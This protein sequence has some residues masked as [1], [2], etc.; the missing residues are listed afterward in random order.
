MSRL[1]LVILLILLLVRIVTVEKMTKMSEG[2]YRY[3]GTRI[4][5]GGGHLAGACV[6]SKYHNHPARY[7]R[8]DA[9][10]WH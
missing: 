9:P 5:P 2:I 1:M 3:S 10:G 4:P 7:A 6:L 8:S